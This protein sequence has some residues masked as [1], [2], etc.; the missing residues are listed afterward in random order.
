[1]PES[2]A[3]AGDCLAFGFDYHD[4]QRTQ[5]FAANRDFIARLQVIYEK[6]I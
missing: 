2:Q 3:V 6:A 1:M 5:A 4:W